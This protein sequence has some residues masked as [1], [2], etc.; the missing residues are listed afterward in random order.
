MRRPT[1]LKKSATFF[2]YFSVMSKHVGDFFKF[3][4]YFISNHKFTGSLHGK[5]KTCENHGYWDAKARI[6]SRDQ[7]GN[8]TTTSSCQS[9]DWLALVLLNRLTDWVQ[10]VRLHIIISLK[11]NMFLPFRHQHSTQCVLDLEI[12]HVSVNQGLRKSDDR[13]LFHGCSL[14]NFLIYLHVRVCDKKWS[15]FDAITS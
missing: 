5:P 14:F 15:K 4:L 13:V 3:L 10:F 8:F 12:S 9:A 6:F 1:N 2:D 11:A 7:A